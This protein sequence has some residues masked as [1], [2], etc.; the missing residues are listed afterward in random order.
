MKSIYS[1]WLKARHRVSWRRLIINGD[2][3]QPFQFESETYLTTVARSLS[4]PVWGCLSRPPH[5]CFCSTVPPL[6]HLHLPPL[7]WISD[8]LSLL[9]PTESPALSSVCV[10]VCVCD[11]WVSSLL[12]F[13]PGKKRRINRWADVLALS[14]SLHS[15]FSPWPLSLF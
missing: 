12:P 4:L 3:K 11:S 13:T 1:S 7:V 8:R 14:P 2:E 10:W 15:F 6:I 5:F 9:L